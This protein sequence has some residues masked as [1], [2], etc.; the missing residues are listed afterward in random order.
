MSH[1]RRTDSTLSRMLGA[2]SLVE[3]LKL[4]QVRHFFF[5]SGGPTSIFSEMSEHSP[6]IRQVLT[7]SE[8]AAAY[9]AD[10]YSRASYKA[11]LCFGQ[12]GP[13][14]ANLAAG[15]AEPYLASSPVIALTGMRPV[16]ALNRN[17]YQE[18]EQMKCFD[19]VTKWNAAVG[20]GNRIP[21]MVRT[22][23]RVAL[24]SRPR[25]VHLSLPADVMSSETEVPPMAVDKR[26]LQLPPLRT[27]PD[28]HDVD[29]A[30]TL[31]ARAER[32]L[33]VA[34][35]GAISS[36]AWT[37]IQQLAENLSIPVATTLSGKGTIAENHPL[38]IGLPGR[39]GRK[40]ASAIMKQADLVFF[41]GCKVGSISSINWT[42][43]SLETK[44]IQ[45]DI[46]PVQIGW[47]Y[48][49]TLGIVGDAKVT[50]EAISRRIRGKK[51][52]TS[53]SRLK[54]VDFARKTTEGWKKESEKLASSESVPI[55]IHR[56]MRD[57]REILDDD[58][59]LVADTGY[60]AAW[61]GTLFEVRKQGRSFYRSAGSLGWAF[62]AAIGAQLALPQSRV[63]CFTGDG[64][65]GYHLTELETAV[66]HNV[67]V[68][69]VINNNSTL[70]FERHDFQY[71]LRGRG[72][73][74]SDYTKT[75]FA[76]IAR[77]FGCHGIT[78]E[79]PSEIKDALKGAIM[80]GTPAVVDI[81]TDP[82]EIAPV[83]DYESYVPRT[84]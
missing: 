62:P 7:H 8:K 30:A 20:K 9:M 69:S 66:R 67:P 14:A 72:Y 47:N 31:L 3:M 25:P 1:S 76:K 71:F 6:E 17:A 40:S 58:A 51:G 64:G 13:G 70:A 22:A 44:I 10:G 49:V 80:A 48:P 79:R 52:I 37:A 59:V 46:D 19:P 55:S 53:P 11:G 26:F 84:V 83:T 33:I 56:V 27:R 82:D 43:I 2:R 54:W 50:C 38:C 18:L 35:G 73:D 60:A 23:F 28:A 65:F 5:M 42:L 34:G 24:S 57:I 29:E 36:K 4:F 61:S 45:V 21:D 12:V 74:A 32:P 78:V 77:A 81:V 63:V 68:V 75:D 41:V 39:Y 16:E 15:I